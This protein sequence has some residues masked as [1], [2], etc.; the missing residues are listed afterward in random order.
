MATTKPTRTKAQQKR[1]HETDLGFSWGVANSAMLVLG[2]GVLATGYLT[3]SRGSIT[4]A[5]VLLVLGY[6][7]F[8]PAS[9]L[10]R[11]RKEGSGE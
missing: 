6:C 10:F 7:V 4:L 11:G 3:L 1:V 8:I 5:P 2:L 9:L